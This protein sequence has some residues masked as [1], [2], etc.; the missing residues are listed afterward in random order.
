[1]INF[2][3]D[4]GVS[5]ISISDAETELTTDKNATARHHFEI[6]ETSVILILLNLILE[7]ICFRFFHL[8]GLLFALCYWL[9]A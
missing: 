5:N 3:P 9:I 2:K 8:F 4:S 7:L 1:M 6:K